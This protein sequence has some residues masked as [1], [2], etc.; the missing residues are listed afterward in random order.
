MNINSIVVSYFI[1]DTRL[2]L[3]IVYRLFYQLF[4]LSELYMTEK[5]TLGVHPS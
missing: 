1:H 2:F 3:S 4:Y 5:V